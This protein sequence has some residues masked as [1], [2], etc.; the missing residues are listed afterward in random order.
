MLKCWASM[1]SRVK[2]YLQYLHCV[3]FVQLDCNCFIWHLCIY[4]ICPVKSFQPSQILFT[5]S[6][7]NVKNSMS[8]KKT[9]NDLRHCNVSD[10]RCPCFEPIVYKNSNQCNFNLYKGDQFNAWELKS[11]ECL[12][13]LVC[14]H[15]LF[16]LIVI[17]KAIWV[18]LNT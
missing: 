10:P 11:L 17:H 4:I 3:N 13:C 8:Y 6:R 9:K 12:W 16:D 15:Y 1:M 7:D 2:M 5:G 18:V 14:K